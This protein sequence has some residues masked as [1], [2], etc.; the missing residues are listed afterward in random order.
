MYASGTSNILTGQSDAYKTQAQLATGRKILAPRDNPVDSTLALL[1]TQAKDVNDTFMANQSAATSGMSYLETQLGS[2]TDLLGHVIE[3]SAQGGTPSYTAQQKQPISDE[4]KSRFNTL[5]DIANSTNASGEYI[6]SGNR[7]N[8]KPFDI[9]GNNSTLAIYSLT[10][11]SINYSGDDGS[12]LIQVESSQTVKTTESGQTVFM[13]MKNQ[14]GSLNGRSV[15][16]ALKNMIDYLDSPA[17]VAAN[18]TQAMDDLKIALGHVSK[19][20]GSVGAQMRQVEALTTAGEDLSVQFESRLSK[21][22]GLDYAEAISRLNQ[23]TT[24]LQASQQSFSKVSQL[25]LFNYIS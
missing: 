20:R 7:T 15:F 17:P 8:T 5:V 2:L 19:V 18:Y 6:F 13:R 14:D 25:N 3:R 12:H 16:D 21:L 22:V 10:N 1:T 24:Q 11:L 23:Q 4:L 9:S